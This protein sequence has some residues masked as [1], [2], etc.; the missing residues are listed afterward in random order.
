MAGSLIKIDEEIVSS[1]VSSVSLTGIDSTY[2]VYMVAINNVTTASDNKDL[3]MQYIKASDS[4]TDSTSN[5]DYAT[6][7]LL[8]NTSFQNNT[9][10]NQTQ[11]II[12]YARGSA[13][14]EQDNNVL[15]LFNT[16]SS[17]EYSFTTL[18]GSG[19]NYGGN[20]G[21]EQGGGVHTVAQ[22]NS[23]VKFTWE[24]GGNFNSGTFR[25]YGLKK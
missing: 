6:K 23:G 1:A 8:S 7:G 19:L 2:N 11:F 13:S 16:F 4:S 14:N 9:S 3:Y 20:L 18:E 22:S 15:Y 5:Y 17:S 25:L 21:S 10:T 24:S 12:Q